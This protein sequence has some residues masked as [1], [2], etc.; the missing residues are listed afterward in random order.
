MGLINVRRGRVSSTVGVSV[1]V[2]SLLASTHANFAPDT[3]TASLVGHG[4]AELGA[5]RKP[6]KLLSAEDGERL[7]LDF[8]TVCDL[9]LSLGCS[10]SLIQL[11]CI[12]GVFQLFVQAETKSVFSFVTDRQVG[13]D[14]IT[15][16]FR[17]IQVH[18]ASHRGA[19]QDGQ[20][21]GVIV[22]NTALSNGAGLLKRCEEEVVSVDAK[23]DVLVRL[24]TLPDA[25]FNNRGRINRTTVRRGC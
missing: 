19:S 25:Q 7:R 15:S 20:S 5:R 8:Q 13:K 4:A 14:E 1:V 12:L 2:L 3:D 9:G 22:R 21:G 6:G 23:G 16:L 24:F 17:T 10:R 18:H 11:V